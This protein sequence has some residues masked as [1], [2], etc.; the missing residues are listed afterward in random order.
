MGVCIIEQRR[1]ARKF[2]DLACG[3]IG[4]A[5]VEDAMVGPAV[6]LA[7]LAQHSDLVT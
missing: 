3:G 1:H 2:F 4:A 5:G 6:A 7:T